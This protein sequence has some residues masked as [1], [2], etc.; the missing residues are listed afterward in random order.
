MKRIKENEELRGLSAS[1]LRE[2][3]DG[4]RRMRFSLQLNSATAHV[5]DYS[6]F[7][8][9]KKSIARVLTLLHEL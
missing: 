7:K 2:K 4:L 6:Q 9:I 5:K 8:K 1:E 3:L